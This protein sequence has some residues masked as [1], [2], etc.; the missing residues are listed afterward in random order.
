MLKVTNENVTKL[1]EDALYIVL[2]SLKESD[3]IYSLIEAELDRRIHI[4][5]QSM[6]KSQQL[7]IESMALIEA[8]QEEIHKIFQGFKGKKTLL[9]IE[10]LGQ[11]YIDDYTID[12]VTFTV[13]SKVA[14]PDQNCSWSFDSMEK[15][16]AKKAMLIYYRIYEKFMRDA[17]VSSIELLQKLAG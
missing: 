2:D 4:Q 5:N 17:T 7:K 11:E 13:Y 15:A 1:S 16:N 12:E 9:L 14:R 6:F 3:P 8:I 10:K